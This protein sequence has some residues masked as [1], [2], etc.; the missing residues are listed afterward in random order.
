MSELFID[1]AEEE[2]S[3]KRALLSS[4]NKWKVMIVDDDE[5]IHEITRPVLKS[6]KFDNKGIEFIHAYSEKEA[7]QLIET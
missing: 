5:G 7:K 3:E 1:F 4:E 2:S 6:L